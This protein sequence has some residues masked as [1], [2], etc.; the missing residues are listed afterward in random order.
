MGD[1]F[2]STLI[3]EHNRLI[4]TTERGLED[5]IVRVL[6][7][8]GINTPARPEPELAYDEVVTEVTSDGAK[9]ILKEKGYKVSSYPGLMAVLDTYKVKGQ[10]KGKNNWYQVK[11]LEAIPR[12]N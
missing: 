7:R 11:D 4:V 8:I 10:K 3:T 12:K 2:H 6:E 1:T 9:R 5:M